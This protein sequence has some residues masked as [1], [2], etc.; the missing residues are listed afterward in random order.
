[1]YPV[2]GLVKGL[3]NMVPAFNSLKAKMAV[4]AKKDKHPYSYEA[5]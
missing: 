2:R 5:I 3:Q 1:M 4:K